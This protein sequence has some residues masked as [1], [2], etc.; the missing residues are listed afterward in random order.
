MR[1][2]AAEFVDVAFWLLQGKRDLVNQHCQDCVAF[3]LTRLSAFQQSNSQ[4]LTEAQKTKDANIGVLQLLS[5]RFTAIQKD[6]KDTKQSNSA[7]IKHLQE[8]VAALVSQGSV[9]D[10]KDSRHCVA[11]FEPRAAT[12]E[13]ELSALQKQVSELQAQQA[14][15]VEESAYMTQVIDEHDLRILAVETA[16]YDGR[17]LWKLSHFSKLMDDARAGRK[18]SFVSSCFVEWQQQE[19]RV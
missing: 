1:A 6:I 16:S 17:I 19:S 3:H 15:I 8:Q 7:K 2:S 12:L 5:D 13:R 11:L 10:G 18:V 4:R 14:K 9:D